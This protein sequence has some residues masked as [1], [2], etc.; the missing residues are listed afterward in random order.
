MGGWIQGEKDRSPNFQG[1]GGRG[2]GVPSNLESKVS[3]LGCFFLP[4][5]QLV[6]FLSLPSS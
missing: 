4:L 5:S 3:F 2:E 6:Y 1:L